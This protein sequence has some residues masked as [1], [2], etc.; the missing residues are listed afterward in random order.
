[1]LAIRDDILKAIKKGEVTIADLSKAF[2]TV[3]YETVLRKLYHV[4]FSKKGFT[5]D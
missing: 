4:G 3:A 2:N 1:M 5:L